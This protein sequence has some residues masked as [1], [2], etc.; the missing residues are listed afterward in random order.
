MVQEITWVVPLLLLPGV[1]LLLMSTSVRYGQIHTEVHH[2]L[3][4]EHSITSWFKWHLHNRAMLFRNALVALYIAAGQFAT[5]GLIGAVMDVVSGPVASYIA[6]SIFTTIGIIC[7][8]FAI[9]ELIRESRLS[10]RVIES[11]LD[12]ITVDDSVGD[13]H[14]HHHKT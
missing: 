8:V 3:E 11:H 5:G 1:G 6:V 9:I 7:L 13:R 12:A 2:L 14:G 4:M 10:L